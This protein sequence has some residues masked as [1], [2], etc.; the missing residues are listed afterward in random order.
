MGSGKRVWFREAQPSVVSSQEFG[1]RQA[2]SIRP[3][4]M[5]LVESGS[6]EQGWARSSEDGGGASPLE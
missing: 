6:L 1:T 3:S 5:K 2:F 4:G